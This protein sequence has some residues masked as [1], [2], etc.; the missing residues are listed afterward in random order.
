[1]NSGIHTHAYSCTYMSPH[2]WVHEYP[3]VCTPQIYK[4]GN[5]QTNKNQ[6]LFHRIRQRLIARDPMSSL[7]VPI[8][9]GA[10]MLTYLHIWHTCIYMT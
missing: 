6:E 4:H 5:K 2:T 8:C 9:E 3:H 1:M 10:S 7:G